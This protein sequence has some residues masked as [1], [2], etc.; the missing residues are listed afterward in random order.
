MK[1]KIINY[2][3]KYQK[4]ILFLSLIVIAIAGIYSNSLDAP[5][6]FDGKSKILAN[7]DIRTVSLY[8]LFKPYQRDADYFDRNDPTRALTFFTFMLNFQYCQLNERG[9]RV[10][11]IFIH[12]LVCTILYFLIIKILNMSNFPGD[13]KTLSFLVV[14][15]FAMH[16]ANTEVVTYIYQRS[17]SL[18]ALFVFLSLFT[19]LNFIEKQNFP[20][21]I[22]S[23]LFFVLGL[24]S[25]QSAIITIGFVLTF[26]Y[27]YKANCSFKNLA[28]TPHIYLPYF[29]IFILF[30]IIR[31]MVR[32]TGQTTAYVKWTNLSYLAI[33]PY[34]ICNYII[35]T[36]IPFNLCAHH[37]LD[38][39]KSYLSPL[40]IIPVGI[41][42]TAIGFI[43]YLILQQ[44]NNTSLKAKLFSFSWFFIA[45]LPVSSFFALTTAMADRRM[46]TAMPGLI[47]CVFL[48]LNH[49]KFKYNFIYVLCI[50]LIPYLAYK[51]YTR[52]QLYN[53][54]KLLWEEVDTLY[55]GHIGTDSRIGNFNLDRGK[56]GE[57]LKR[58]DEGLKKDPYNIALWQSKGHL[59]YTQKQYNKAIAC[60]NRVI[61]IE[62]SFAEAYKNK[63]HALLK[64]NDSKQ[65]LESYMS[66]LKLF[67]KD[68]ELLNNIGVIH[69][70]D[71]NYQAAVNYFEEALRIDKSYVTARINLATTL[72]DVEQYDA[73]VLAFEK[74]LKEDS[75][76]RE[77]LQNL[78]WV[79]T[80]ILLQPKKTIYYYTRL[81]NFHPD[82]AQRKNVFS[83][84]G[85]SYA[86]LKDNKKAIKFFNLALAIDPDFFEASFNKAV[87][88]SFSGQ[89]VKAIDIIKSLIEKYPQKGFLYVR[90]IE[91]YK[92]TKQDQKA[93]KLYSIFKGKFSNNTQSIAK[94]EEILNPNNTK[95]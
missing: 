91:I 68:T 15:F 65:A 2:I 85:L 11:N 16:P 20:Y 95:K 50:I 25:K 12:M 76:N 18:A 63:G 28:K 13:I 81:L 52:N 78:G 32:D 41:M 48:Y 72:L 58:Y 1:T 69:K 82:I 38:P 57:A 10:V 83:D 8:K 33:Q 56:F 14:A 77:A 44:T 79:Y 88:L 62:P 61:E 36:F 49:K 71:Q 54:P 45:L 75:T 89:E 60:Y 47:C 94:I 26:Y 92:R 5:F 19:F 9:F 87:T 84:I 42:L 59:F 23:V 74:V 3:N 17:E 39:L 29:S 86:M 53:N 80:H 73:A 37:I 67:K 30:E 35:K 40:F 93:I 22:I 64:L 31:F 90:L 21:M 46:Y 6:F 7:K 27:V 70:K 24:F 66:A 55:K 34:V 43:I 51:T 4:D